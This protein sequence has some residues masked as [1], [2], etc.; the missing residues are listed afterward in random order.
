[1]G[2]SH[3]RCRCLCLL[4]AEERA[5]IGREVSLKVV[6]LLCFSLLILAG[7]PGD[8]PV[9][10]AAMMGDLDEVRLLLSGGADVNAAHADGMTALHW[11][12]E[13]AHTEMSSL[14][15]T[16]GANLEAVTRIGGYTPLHL[17]TRKGSRGV[18]S[19]LLEAGADPRA[20]TET[21]KVTPLHF[22]A[23]A[24]EVGLTSSLIAHGVDVDVRESTWGQTPLIFASSAGHL[25]VV[26]VLLSSGADASLT[27]KVVDIPV[28]DEV[29]RTART[30]RNEMLEA[31]KSAAMGGPSW[32]PE[33]NQVRA[34]VQAAQQ[35]QRSLTSV[36]DAPEREEQPGAQL[37]APLGYTELVGRQGGLTP[38]LHA[39]REGHV[40]IVLALVDF[41]ADINQVS[42][43]DRTSPILMATINGHFD[44]ALLLLDHGAD[45]TVA[46]DAGAT[47]LF[48]SLN[49]HWAPKSRYP[50]Q[51][52][53]RQQDATYLDVM[54]RL[55]EAG[56]DPNVRLRKHIW[57]MSY[58][59]D[60]L[61]VNTIGAT[62]FWRAAYA[63][64]VDAMKLLVEYGADYGVP[65]LKPPGGGRGG[66]GGA[67]SSEDPSGLAPVPEGGPGVF[68]I[69]A[70]SG[71]G[72]GEG[73]AGNSHRHVPDGW[74]PAVKYLIGELGVDV[75]AR[76]HN[77]YSPVHHAAARGDNELIHYLV[78]Q[79]ADVTFISRRGQTTVDMANGPQQRIS[80]FPETISLLESLGAKN[81][82]N[83]L[84]C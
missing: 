51:H 26:H 24:G 56:V 33:P 48:S 18:A 10:D 25:D 52:A 30:V 69:H 38:L 64:D 13:N 42:D 79:G 68:P 45:P 43:G 82:H 72:Y 31:F 7:T 66:R 40:D 20:E 5:L 70:A 71:V 75:N 35:V 37:E 55:L 47:P 83:C 67:S 60:L 32:R 27:T 2:S 46:S 23:S 58:T 34:A 3:G 65:T 22:A 53:Y 54:K 62:P 76:D 81:N 19:S 17:A 80:P 11:A 36:P 41:G 14:L 50:Q 9:A 77:G 4:I 1:M 28:L 78:Q 63:T 6:G 84:S 15:V 39:V 12:A 29:D 73:Y 49:T 61:R 59:F 21:G 16:A 57:Y 44:L 74:V 8:S